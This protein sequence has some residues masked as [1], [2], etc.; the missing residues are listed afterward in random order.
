VN[1]E[2]LGD[3][4]DR[5]TGLTVTS[6][7]HDVIAELPRIGLGHGYILPARLHGKPSQMSPIRA[8]D[9]AECLLGALEGSVGLH[10]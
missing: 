4:L 8:A 9:P 3:L 1:P 6:D 7:P 10:G 2:V 5:H